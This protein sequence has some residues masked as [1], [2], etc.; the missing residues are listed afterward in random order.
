MKGVEFTPRLLPHSITM[1]FS[2]QKSGYVS[3]IS[4]FIADLKKKDPTLEEKQRAGRARLWDKGPIDLDAKQRNQESR[5]K[6]KAYVY[7]TK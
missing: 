2:V 5:V 7:Q 1:K 3:E 6:Q 4:H